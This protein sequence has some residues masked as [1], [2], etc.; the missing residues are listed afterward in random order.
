MALKLEQALGGHRLG[1][2][3]GIPALEPTSSG[4]AQITRCISQCFRLLAAYLAHFCS[5]SCA[6][7]LSSVWKRC[8]STPFGA[9]LWTVEWHGLQ[10]NTPWECRKWCVGSAMGTSSKSP[11]GKPLPRYRWWVS[12]GTRWWNVSL[13]VRAHIWHTPWLSRVAAALA[14]P[15]SSST[16]EASRVTSCAAVRCTLPHSRNRTSTA[17]PCMGLSAELPAGQRSE[18]DGRI[19]AW[20]HSPSSASTARTSSPGARGCG[21]GGR[22]QSTRRLSSATMTRLAPTADASSS[23]HPNGMQACSSTISCNSSIQAASQSSSRRE[24]AASMKELATISRVPE[25]ASKR[26]ASKAPIS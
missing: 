6:S 22:L 17:E 18:L 9:N 3:I 12:L 5:G 8:A 11:S 24:V 1:I 25:G 13:V 19:F 15:S 14:S 26:S 4:A 16:A 7:S 2:G 23:L 21:G 10:S 20:C